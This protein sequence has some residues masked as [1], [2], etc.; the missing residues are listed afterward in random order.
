MEGFPKPGD[1]VILKSGG[2]KMT[3]VG[4]GK[5]GYSEVEQALCR[6]FKSGNEFVEDVFPF[7]SIALDPAIL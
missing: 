6:W 4:V 7:E 5:Y 1:V 3:V 2:P